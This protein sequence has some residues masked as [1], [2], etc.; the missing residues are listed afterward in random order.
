MQPLIILNTVG[1]TSRLLERAPRLHALALAQWARPLRETLP[2][3]TCSAQASMILL[4]GDFLGS[5][6]G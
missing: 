5:E 4:A 3:V 6:L 1:L 2:A